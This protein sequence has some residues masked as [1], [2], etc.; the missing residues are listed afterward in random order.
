MSSVIGLGDKRGEVVAIAG[1]IFLR[2]AFA[3]FELAR[4]FRNVRGNFDPALLEKLAHQG[5]GV[6]IVI[7][8]QNLVQLQWQVR[9][10]K[11][12]KSKNS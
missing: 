12:E 9:C 7:F 2:K 10:L 5:V 4:E 11:Q 3:F 1:F 8:A 6:G